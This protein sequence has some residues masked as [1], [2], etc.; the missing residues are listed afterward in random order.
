MTT[1]RNVPAFEMPKSRGEDGKATI[2]DVDI[3]REASI[4]MIRAEKADR[5]DFAVMSAM[6]QAQ[7][8]R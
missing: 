7:L 4:A 2:F 8:G 1:S 5:E 6:R 3:G